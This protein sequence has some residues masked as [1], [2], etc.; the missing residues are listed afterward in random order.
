MSIRQR[1]L[2]SLLLAIALTLGC[3]SSKITL[4]EAYQA[5]RPVKQLEL[6]EQTTENL[7]ITISNVA[8][9]GSSYKNRLEVFVNDKLLMPNWTVSNVENEFV[10]LLRLRPGYYQV[11][12][13][14]YAFI[15][16]SEEKYLIQSQD[17]VPVFAEKV[18]RLE[19]RIEKQSN[20]EPINKK[21]FFKSKT[22]PVQAK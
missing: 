19:H 12:A 15:G 7:I 11:K 5:L 3:A 20:G 22:E 6:P 14:Y 21:M 9:E 16:W 13:H 17:L 4:D 8:D 18:T 2:F 1:S 10:Y